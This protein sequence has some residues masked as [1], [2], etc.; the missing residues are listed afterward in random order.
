MLL[1]DV[2]YRTNSSS[3]SLRA[4]LRDLCV[5]AYVYAYVYMHMMRGTSIMTWVRT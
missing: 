1:R 4:Y 5:N 3:G 2:W